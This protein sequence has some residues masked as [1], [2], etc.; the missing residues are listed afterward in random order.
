MF[1]FRKKKK[2]RPTKD[3]YLV[4]FSARELG[5]G[6]VCNLLYYLYKKYGWVHITYIIKNVGGAVRYELHTDDKFR[7]TAFMKY[8]F[9]DRTSSQIEELCMSLRDTIE[10]DGRYTSSNT[11]DDEFID[12]EVWKW[13]EVKGN[14]CKEEES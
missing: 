11:F 7:Q 3:T 5:T 1:S 13:K 6:D 8:F 12:F 9:K 4:D 2:W 14:E 10:I